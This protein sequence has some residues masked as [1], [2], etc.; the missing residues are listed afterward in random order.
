MGLGT[1]R[2]DRQVDGTQHLIRD[3]TEKQFVNPPQAPSSKNETVWMELT[4]RR[5]DFARRWLAVT[6]DS[7][8]MKA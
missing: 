2:K 1:H 5:Q 6:Y 4:N 8:A 3:G 7:R